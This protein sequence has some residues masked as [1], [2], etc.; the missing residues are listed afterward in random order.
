ML[1]CTSINLI[2][3]KVAFKVKK[4]LQLPVANHIWGLWV[5]LTKKSGMTLDACLFIV[6]VM[7]DSVISGGSLVKSTS[8]NKTLL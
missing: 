8:S 3:E 5:F 4:K 1:L 7:S 6:T 2:E